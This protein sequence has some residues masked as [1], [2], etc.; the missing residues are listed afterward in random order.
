MPEEKKDS[1]P[2]PRINAST[3]PKSKPEF[4]LATD[5]EVETI[6]PKG[7]QPAPKPIVPKTGGFQTP[8]Q[9]S[10]QVS[11]RDTQLMQ[12]AS[13]GAQALINE[14]FRVQTIDEQVVRDKEL[15]SIVGKDLT[16]DNLFK[17]VHNPASPM[18]LSIGGGKY[19]VKVNNADELG[20]ALQDPYNLDQFFLANRSELAQYFR[21]GSSKELTDKLQGGLTQYEKSIYSNQDAVSVYDPRFNKPFQAN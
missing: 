6:T 18:P 12:A 5:K 17:A 3:T 4:R 20:Q 2:T 16:F 7:N 21:I 19:E 9:G 10:Q 8:R 11:S 15:E 14:S 1:K 13:K